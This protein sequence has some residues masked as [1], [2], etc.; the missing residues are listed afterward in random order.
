MMNTVCRSVL[1]FVASLLLQSSIAHGQEGGG[2]AATKARLDNLLPQAMRDNNV[3]MW[4][5]VVPP[6]NP[7][8]PGVETD[9]LQLGVSSGYCIFTDR[10]G[11]RIERGVF[12]SFGGIPA[13]DLYDVIGDETAGMWSAGSRFRDIGKFVAD[14]DP[15]SIAID[16]SGISYADYKQLTDK[17]GEKYTERI[18]SADDLLADFRPSSVSGRDSRYYQQPEAWTNLIRRDKFDFVL[19][20]VMR[21]NEI[22]LWIHVIRDWDLVNLGASAGYGVFADR[23]GD[24]IERVLYSYNDDVLDAS[25]YDVVNLI[26][27]DDRRF[28]GLKEFVATRD[29]KRIGVNFSERLQFADGISFED[30]T[31]LVEAIGDKYA[32]RI[33]SADILVTNYLSGKVV[34]ELVSFGKSGDALDDRMGSRFEGI[35]PGVTALNELR[36]NIFVRNRDGYESLQDNYIIQRGDLVSNPGASA[37]ILREGEIELPPEHQKLWEHAMVVRD[38]LRRNIFPGR[39][40]GETLAILIKK[41]EEAGYAYTDRDQYNRDLDPDKTQVHLDLHTM[42]VADELIGPR[43]SPW[44]PDWVRDLKIPLNHTLTLEYM[45]HMPVPKWGPGK[46]LYLPFHDP[47][48]VTERGVEFPYPPIHKIHLVH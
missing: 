1:F 28:A 14:R 47:G 19:P 7:F 4:L 26:A 11:D 8:G 37:Y 22:D 41:L 30:Y 23:G 3:D 48:V 25:A 36:G 16:L 33:V 24:R 15:Q 44:A 40:G 20:Q 35:E 13:Q 21:D 18:I 34:S 2:S 9:P 12:D 39:T 10:G 6:W 29:P 42:G 5:H 38:I 31:L 17:L 43:I 46:H 27:N 32:E 45:I